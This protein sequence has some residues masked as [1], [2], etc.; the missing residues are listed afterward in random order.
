MINAKE[1]KPDTE[2]VCSK[3]TLF[4]TVDRMEGEKV[5]K[6]K[7]DKA[8]HHHYI[9]LEWVT[10]VDSKIHIS[11]PGDQAMKQW[12]TSAK[13][14]VAG[15]KTDDSQKAT[16]APTKSMSFKP[17]PKAGAKKPAHH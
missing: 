1:I 9:P 12:S 16:G 8:G 14:A 17:G 7:K 5:I 6:L 10:K 11:L 2:V 15:A 3:N 4:A 13:P